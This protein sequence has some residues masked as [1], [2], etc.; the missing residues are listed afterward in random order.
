[1]TRRYMDTNT[2][3]LTGV[4]ATLVTILTISMTALLVDNP[5]VQPTPCPALMAMWDDIRTDDKDDVL[6]GN[7]AAGEALV[8]AIIRCNGASAGRL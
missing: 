7:G 2:A 1:M 4:I 8:N 6:E 3:I 5:P